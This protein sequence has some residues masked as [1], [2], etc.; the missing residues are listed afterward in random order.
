[1][2]LEAMAETWK[3]NQEKNA[4]YLSYEKTLQAKAAR[5]QE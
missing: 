3:T 4:E 2:K 5:E 1:V